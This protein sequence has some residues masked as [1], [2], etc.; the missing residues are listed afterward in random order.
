M[1]AAERISKCKGL[2]VLDHSFFATMVLGCEYKEDSTLP[3]NIN[4]YTNGVLIGYN[5]INVEKMT[6]SECITFLAHEGV[7]NVLEHMVRREGRDPELWNMATD[8]A[9]N[10]L[11]KDAEFYIHPDRPC[12][13]KYSNMDAEKI[14]EL[15][16]ENQQDG[17]KQQGSSNDEVRDL[18]SDSNP[19]N[20]A[21][22]A[23]VEKWKQENKELL[24][25]AAQV[26]KQA[27]NIPGSLAAMIEALLNPKINWAEQLRQYVCR[28][29]QSDYDW[30]TGDENQLV[31]NE[32][33][34][35]AL[36]DHD[37]G[38]EV[39]IGIDTSGS[40][41]DSKDQ[42]ASEISSI[43]SEFDAKIRNLY[44]DTC[45]TKDEELTSQDLPLNLTWNGCGGTSYK[46]LFE[47]IGNDSPNL[48]I[49]FSD[50]E[51]DSYPDK[52][53]DYPVLWVVTKDGMGAMPKF[54]EVIRM[55]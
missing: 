46:P 1:T 49:I 5:P 12:D 36:A 2:L 34:I 17:K 51:T 15:M 3:P 29:F 27:G 22:M 37:N 47:K 13:A 33:Y 7:H 35:P 6:D 20:Q 9:V 4:G 54:G 55:N 14:Y 28:A 11:L 50:L 31:L 8:Q 43:L 53:P 21:S 18:P 48:L 26:A 45:I 39:V 38:L 24:T 40:C 30:A 44:F 42:F 16:L 23:E 52:V 10:N 25:Q 19:N 41:W 32:L